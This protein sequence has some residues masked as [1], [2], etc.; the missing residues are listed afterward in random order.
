MKYKVG[1]KVTLTNGDI[2][3]VDQI[4]DKFKWYFMREDPLNCYTDEMI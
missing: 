2:M 4:N 3:T 1:D